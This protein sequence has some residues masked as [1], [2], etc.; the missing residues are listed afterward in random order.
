MPT[1]I[2]SPVGSAPAPTM[3]ADPLF[4]GQQFVSRSTGALTDTS[5]KV[6]TSAESGASV[7][8]GLYYAYV[9]DSTNQLCLF[10]ITGGDTV[11]ILQDIAT[12]FT[13][14]N[15]TNDKVN[16]DITSTTLRVENQL[17]TTQT[18]ELVKLL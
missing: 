2:P 8:N 5:A 18:I 1:E 16:I 4:T 15:T 11:T 17:G 10:S 12:K 6:F 3:Y 13:T 9:K 14:T 7:M